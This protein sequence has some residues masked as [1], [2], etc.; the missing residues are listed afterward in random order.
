MVLEPVFHYGDAFAETYAP[1]MSIPVWFL[2]GSVIGGVVGQFKSNKK[3]S[4]EASS[5]ETPKN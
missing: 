3:S 5:V 2:T 4:R 1:I